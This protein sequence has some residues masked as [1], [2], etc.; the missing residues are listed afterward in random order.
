TKSRFDNF[1]GTG[2]S[3][4]DCIIRATDVLL[5]GKNFV[6]AGFGNCG[7]GLALKARGMGC[8]VIVTEVDPVKALQ[9]KML[10]YSVMAMEQAAKIGDVFVTVTGNKHVL[11]KEHF[12]LMKD[13]AIVCNTGHFNV[14]INIGELS[15]VSLG[16]KLVRPDVEE[17]KLKSNG[18]RIYLLAEGRLVNLA[19]AKGHP[20]EVMDMSFANQALCSEFIVKNKGKL[21]K[22]V[23]DVPKEIDEGVALLKLQAMGTTIDKLTAEQVKYLASWNEGT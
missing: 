16:K 5:A 14:E 4:L 9:A 3:T 23:Y 22:Q 21:K 1:Y 7:S 18:N 2:Q 10:G 15:S 20:S 12:L 6:V 13:K 8:N 17:F 11:R 19:C